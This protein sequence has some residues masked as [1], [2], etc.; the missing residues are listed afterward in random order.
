MRTAE[1]F[2]STA[3]R[4]H[5]VRCLGGGWEL[6]LRLWTSVL[7]RELEVAV[8]RQPEGLGSS[9]PVAG[10]QSAKLRES[11][12]RSGPVGEARHHCWGGWTATGISFPAHVQTLRGQGT[13][14]RGYRWQ[15]A[16]CASD[17]WLG[18]SCTG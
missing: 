17:G 2:G 3:T 16:T 15:D 12:R 18:T 11:R 6:R 5:S 1:T 10:E 13:S 9:V 14:S 8:W 4:H 7:E